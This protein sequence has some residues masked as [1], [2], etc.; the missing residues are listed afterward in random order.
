V[1]FDEV[2]HLIV[3]CHRQ[4]RQRLE[5]IDHAHARFQVA[6]GKFPDYERVGSR[7]P[8]LQDLN[9][10]GIAAAKVIYPN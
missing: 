5:Q 7:L 4:L 2:K 9:D 6:A 1:S 3:H 10:Q 8:R